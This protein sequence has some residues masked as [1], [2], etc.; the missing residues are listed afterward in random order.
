MTRLDKT[1]LMTNFLK[2]VK[3]FIYKQFATGP[4]EHPTRLGDVLTQSSS[5]HY[6]ALVKVTFMLL[7][8]DIQE[9]QSSWN[10]GWRRPRVSDTIWY[11]HNY[12]HGAADWVLFASAANELAAHH[13]LVLAVAVLQKHFPCSTCIYLLWGDIMYVYIIAVFLAHISMSV[14]VLAVAS[15]GI[16][17]SAAA[18]A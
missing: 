4:W 15:P 16:C 11:K 12:S 9:I 5:H 1:N 6:L 3:Q 2:L 10:S 8:H 18:T 13:W 7:T 14:D 17:S